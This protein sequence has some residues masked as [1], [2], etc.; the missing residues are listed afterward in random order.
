M[1]LA[2]HNS[3]DRGRRYKTPGSETKIFITRSVAGCISFVFAELPLLSFPTWMTQEGSG[4]CFT[5]CSFASQPRN[6]KI[7]ES[8][9]FIK[10]SQPD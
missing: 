7:R 6:A 10:N 2:S 5:S 4:E 9:S 8:E 1:K 3:M